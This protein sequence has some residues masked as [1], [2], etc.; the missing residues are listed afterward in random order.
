M[1]CNP[2]NYRGPE[3]LLAYPGLAVP[4]LQ[5]HSWDLCLQNIMPNVFFFIHRLVV[6][7]KEPWRAAERKIIL[8]VLFWKLWK[9]K[10]RQ[11]LRGCWNSRLKSRGAVEEG[12][13]LWICVWFTLLGSQWKRFYWFCWELSHVLLLDRVALCHCKLGD[14]TLKLNIRNFG[15][16][17]K[18]GQEQVMGSC[19]RE[20]KYN[21][22]V[23]SFLQ[24]K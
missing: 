2:Q 4:I 11:F 5:H 10:Q 17:E 3:A 19:S 15:Y 22:A 6:L 20:G 12:S 21:R 7:S 13:Q 24:C 23:G 9:K 8:S 16:R 14:K 18:S 1:I